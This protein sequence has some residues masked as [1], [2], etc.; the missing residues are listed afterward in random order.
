MNTWGFSL[1]KKLKKLLPKKEI[2]YWAEEPI[3]KPPEKG[4]SNRIVKTRIT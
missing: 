4:W 3:E 1:T 2:W